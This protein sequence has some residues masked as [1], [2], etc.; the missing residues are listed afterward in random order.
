M[1]FYLN[2]WKQNV[3]CADEHPPVGILMC[4]DKDHTKVDFAT[5]G[6]S[7]KLFVSRYLTLLPSA[8]QLQHFVQADRAKVETAM[9]QHARSSAKPTAAIGRPKKAKSLMPGLL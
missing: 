1:N 2:W 7:N 8:E 9:E 6:M 4:S 3:T 5:G